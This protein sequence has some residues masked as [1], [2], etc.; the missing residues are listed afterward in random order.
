M[1]TASAE[2]SKYRNVS[3][4]LVHTPNS[5]NFILDC[6]EGS[7]SQ[8]YRCFPEEIADDIILNLK[9]I[10]I[11][12]LH[13]DHHLGIISILKKREQLLAAKKRAEENLMT[14]S[15]T[16][17]QRSDVVVIAPDKNVSWMTR[18]GK[19]IEKLPCTL[20]DCCTLTKDKM[21]TTQ[22]A[23]SARMMNLHFET[24]PVIHC[25]E[26]YG[27]VVRHASGWSMAYSGDTRPCPELVQAGRGVSLLIHEATFEDGLVD[28]AVA[29]KHCTVSEALEISD[30]MK[31]E[32]TILTHFSQ[33]YPK[34]PSF[35]M[36]DQLH[37]RVAIAFDCMS[38]NLKRL[39]ELHS[40]LP[41]MRDIFTEVVGVDDYELPHVHTMASSWDFTDPL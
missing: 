12:H 11:S 39:D 15:A 27:V 24:V 36:A 9:V 4:I 7:L 22:V 35:L 25:Y 38:V 10:F 1:G 33:R 20:I 14:S 2:P 34:I 18:Y 26:A 21:E 37:S 8:I 17:N 6:G 30:K 5:G 32:F 29:K 23:D 28:R 19:F 3:G 16:S 41:V 13:G 31:P 40:F